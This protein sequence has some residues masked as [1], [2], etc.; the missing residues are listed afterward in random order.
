MSENGQWSEGLGDDMGD[1]EELRVAEP[2]SA[3]IDRMLAGEPLDVENPELAVAERLGRLNTALPPVDT[4]FEERV[5][6]PLRRSERQPPLL[7]FPVR[8]LAL[9]AAVTLVV[10]ALVLTVPGQ[11][12]LARLA[13]V[14]QLDSVQV[15]IN[16]ATATPADPQWVYGPRTERSLDSLE[17]AQ[18]VA[19]API[20]VP[21]DLPAGWSLRDARA[22]YYPELPADVP[23]NVV[24]TFES[25]SGAS[26]ELEVIEH[27]IRLGDDLTIDSLSRVDERST[28]VREVRVGGRRAILVESREADG[29][30]TLIWQQAGILLEIEGH[31]LQLDDLVAIA[32]SMAPVE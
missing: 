9:A 24:L 10:L 31:G 32:A 25:A 29:G 20:L 1:A 13:A 14:F 6:V 4:A 3:Q 19:P 30:H 12:A 8:P 15:G 17:A 21:S 5:M 28:S 18:Q 22:V 2:V 26:L 27:F 23:L 7:R 16:V 11:M